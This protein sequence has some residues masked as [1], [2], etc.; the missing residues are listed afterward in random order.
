M[1]VLR[2][3]TPWKVSDN[4]GGRDVSLLLI[5]RPQVQAERFA[6]Q[7]QARFGENV[8]ILI[9]PVLRI[10]QTDAPVP[11]TGVSGLI[12]T[13]E[14]GVWAFGAKTDTRLG[15]AYCVGER[16]VAAAQELGLAV[17]VVAD[18][19]AALADLLLAN[20][21]GGRLLHIRGRHARGDIAARLTGGGQPCD[22]VV[23][24]DQ[25]PQA[26]S[27]EAMAALSGTQP[28][29]LP[30]FSPRSAKLVA[31]AAKD[32][33]A[34]LVLAA[35]SPAVASAW[36]GPAPTLQQIAQRPDSAAMLD[37]LDVLNDAVERLEGEAGTG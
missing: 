14:N 6:R 19:A 30:L 10:V 28:V 9:S 13:S 15:A 27:A 21:P 18:E 24:Y 3:V 36:S 22:E 33:S 37:V 11:L 2:Q 31:K 34:P 16:T 23:V 32:A 4:P 25:A 7:V 8:P 5:T 17:A 26:L 20:P 1:R 29:F 12:F 35:F